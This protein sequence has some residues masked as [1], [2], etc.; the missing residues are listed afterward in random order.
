[1]TKDPTLTGEDP[2]VAAAELA[3]GLLE[4]EERA[5]A[6]R[7][8]LAEPGFAQQV[9][10]WR[11]HLAQLFDVWPE[12]DAPSGVMERV[13]LALDGPA[14]PPPVTLLRTGRLWPGLAAASSLIAA[15]LLMIVLIRPAPPV[16]V[17][18]PPKQQPVAAAP[19]RMLVASID[20]S[21]AGKP[22]TAVYDP[23]T[24]GLRL[25]ESTLADANRSAE[26][27]VIAAD[28]IPHSLGLLRTSGGTNFTLAGDKRARLAVGA[29]LAISLE[30]VGGSPTGLPTGPV[31]ATGALS[32]V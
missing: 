14:T 18:V 17:A 21:A 29:T 28:G 22:V 1:M 25:T 4:G 32:Q 6:L 8:V 3:L 31:V 20:P 27:W 23:V 12:V 16:P 5:V 15:S 9:E 13:D 10:R 30:P 24:G 2:D 26:L 19:A 11:L 7:R